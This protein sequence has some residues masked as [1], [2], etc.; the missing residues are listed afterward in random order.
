M[1]GYKTGSDKYEYVG[2][3]LLVNSNNAWDIFEVG[4]NVDTIIHFPNSFEERCF[5]SMTT[6]RGYDQLD[7]LYDNYP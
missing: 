6:E 7:R 3:T 1:C 4:W 2:T 5:W